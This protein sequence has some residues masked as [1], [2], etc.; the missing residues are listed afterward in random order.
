M[1]VT[2]IGSH[3]G[4]IPRALNSP[5]PISSNNELVFL[6]HANVVSISKS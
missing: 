1:G 2:S 4:I 6:S 3:D 5:T